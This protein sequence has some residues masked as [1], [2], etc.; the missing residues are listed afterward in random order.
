VVHVDKSV[1]VPLQSIVCE[2]LGMAAA[3][4]RSRWIEKEPN[5][6]LFFIVG[7]ILKIDFLRKS[8]E[9]D[10]EVTNGCEEIESKPKP[11]GTVSIS[12]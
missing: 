7:K 6:K 1:G 12:G 3:K 11:L 4:E 5:F 8:C 2:R 10:F 9:V